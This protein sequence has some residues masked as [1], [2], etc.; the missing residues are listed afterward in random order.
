M[1]MAIP[2]WTTADNVVHTN[3][4]NALKHDLMLVLAKAGENEVGAKRIVDKLDHDSIDKMTEYLNKIKDEMDAPAN[5]LVVRNEQPQL[6]F[7]EAQTPDT[8]AASGD[9]IVVI[10]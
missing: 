4:L 9:R 7:G 3:F 6:A 10:A 1:P 2:S 5:Y 8:T